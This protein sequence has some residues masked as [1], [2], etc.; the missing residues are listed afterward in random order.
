MT[1]LGSAWR[2][3]STVTRILA[4]I[5]EQRYTGSATLLVRYINQGRADPERVALSPRRLVSWLMS[6]PAD[7]PDQLAATSTT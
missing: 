3:R 7:L 4:E 2:R 5:R 6:R 1:W